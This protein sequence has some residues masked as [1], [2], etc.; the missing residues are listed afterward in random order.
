MQFLSVYTTL[1]CWTLL[2]V[3]LANCKWRPWPH[4]LSGG[5]QW[6][7]SPQG[8]W[9]LPYQLIPFS[10]LAVWHEQSPS[11]GALHSLQGRVTDSNSLDNK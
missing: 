8:L 5:V 11:I 4:D 3:V 9:E 10:F 1:A 7:F 2:A 6:N